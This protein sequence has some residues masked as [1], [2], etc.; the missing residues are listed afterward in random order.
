MQIPIEIIDS[1]RSLYPLQDFEVKA[2]EE[3][4]KQSKPLPMLERFEGCE[5]REE[6][7]YYCPCCN[8]D[9]SYYNVEKIKYC[10]MCGQRLLL[11]D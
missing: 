9:L 6:R 4:V 11:Q 7:V 3:V 2:I 1:L 8:E 10:P 5:D